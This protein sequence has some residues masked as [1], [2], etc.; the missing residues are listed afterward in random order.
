MGIPSYFSYIIKNHSNIIRSLRQCSR[1]QILLMDCNSIVYDAYYAIEKEYATTKYIKRDHIEDIIIQRVIENIKKYIAYIQPTDFIYIAFDGVAPLAKMS[2]Q[3]TRRYKS[4]FT[5]KIEEKGKLWNTVAITPGTIFSKKLSSAVTREFQNNHIL[6]GVQKMVVSCTDEVGEGEHKLFQYMRENPCTTSEIAVYGLDSD[7]IM[8]SIFHQMFCKNIHVFR[9][10][11]EFIKSIRNMPLPND[12]ILFLNIN[13]F[14]ICMF[15]EMNAENYCNIYDYIFLCFFLGNDFL[16][17]F[18]ALN[19]RT[20]GIQ[21]LLDTYKSH[22]HK[23]PQFSLIDSNNNTILWDNVK[24]FLHDLA[25]NEQSNISKEL[26]E[27]KKWDKKYWLE[28]TEEDK[29]N[30]LQ[31]TPVIYREQEKYINPSIPNWKNRYYRILFDD[32]DIVDEICRNY[33]EGLEWVFKYYT[34]GCPNWRWKYNYHY[35]PLLSDLLNYLRRTDTTNDFIQINAKPYSSYQQLAYVL[36]YQYLNL[37]PIKYMTILREQYREQYPMNWDFQWA[38]CRYFW[39]AH[40][41]LKEINIDKMKFLEDKKRERDKMG[42]LPY[43]NSR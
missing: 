38:F 9:E 34:Q 5:S 23:N 25:N 2:Q 21:I 41:I 20:H 31:N 4:F 19:I 12:K 42:K 10:A 43:D 30:I 29:A 14:S 7:L 36:P 26:E 33:L 3:R 39:E 1:F 18:P 27:R 17:H 8:L 37:L 28:N 16:P 35:P 11:P 6:Y 32:N 15:E 13:E 22:V 40:P 24:L